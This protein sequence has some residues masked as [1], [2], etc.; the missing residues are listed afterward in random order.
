M[1]NE[2]LVS[3]DFYSSNKDCS[4]QIYV[5]DGHVSSTTAF[6]DIEKAHELMSDLAS[7]IEKVKSGD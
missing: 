6:I 3:I 4:I 2:S 1:D 5:F 7:A